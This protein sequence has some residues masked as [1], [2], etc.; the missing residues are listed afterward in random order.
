MLSCS[1]TSALVCLSL[2]RSA[3]STGQNLSS[4][5]FLSSALP[6]L[7]SEP[8]LLSLSLILRD[9]HSC[10]KPTSCPLSRS[11]TS[12]L[13]SSSHVEQPPLSS[14]AQLRYEKFPPPPDPISIIISG[15]WQIMSTC[16]PRWW[17]PRRG[18]G[19]RGQR[20]ERAKGRKS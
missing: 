3:T 15:H 9:L 1:L 7:W 14:E 2:S 8:K 12:S 18:N 5:L 6:P 16:L 20:S 4:C 10:L 11:A 13:A 17:I 19:L